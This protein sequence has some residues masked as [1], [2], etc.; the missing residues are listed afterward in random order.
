MDFDLRQHES[1]KYDSDRQII[2]GFI[3]LVT[4]TVNGL[5]YVGQTTASIEERWRQHVVEAGCCSDRHKTSIE[6]AIQEYGVDNF[7]VSMLEHIIGQPRAFLD[8]RECFWIRYYKTCTLDYGE[9]AGYNRTRG[10]HSAWTMFDATDEARI[11]HLWHEHKSLTEIATIMKASPKLVRNVLS[12]FG[13]QKLTPDEVTQRQR[14]ICGFTV[15]CLDTESNVIQEF[16]SSMLAA[17]WIIQTGKSRTT[18]VGGVASFIRNACVR[19]SY[20]YGFKWN[21][22]DMSDEERCLR[23]KQLQMSKQNSDSRANH[24]LQ[25][26]CPVCGVAITDGATYCTKHKKSSQYIG[27]KDSIVI[28]GHTIMRDECIELL[29]FCSWEALGHKYGVSANAVKKAVKKHFGIQ[30]NR[31]SQYR[32]WNS[33]SQRYEFYDDFPLTDEEIQGLR[34]SGCLL[35]TM[36]E[37]YKISES[38]WYKYKKMIKQQRDNRRN[39]TLDA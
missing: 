3:Y 35:K 8:Q 23:L 19:D 37:E 13:I 18:Y 17:E 6:Q 14:A 21:M 9:D 4:N 22:P 25:K 32:L 5:Q 27:L 39:G 24:R 2:N 28:N 34:K 30:I 7:E 11:I 20:A 33:Q 38:T 15:V 16:A 12:K 36:L 29:K 31:Q 26:T 10:G 1:Y